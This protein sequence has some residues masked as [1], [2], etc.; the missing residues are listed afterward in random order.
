MPQ[1]RHLHPLPPRS[2]LLPLRAPSSCSAMAPPAPPAHSSCSAAGTSAPLV[3]LSHGGGGGSAPPA[4]PRRR[5]QLCP[6]HPARPQRRRQLRPP[7]SARPRQHRQ[8]RPPSLARA[9]APP[10]SAPAVAR[11]RSGSRPALRCRASAPARR[12]SAREGRRAKVESEM[13]EQPEPLGA[14]ILWL[15]TLPPAPVTGNPGALASE[16]E[17]ESGFSTVGQS[18]G[19]SRFWSRGRSPA[20]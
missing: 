5:R 14:S 12:R 16:L 13:E 4:R 3:R 2:S 15:L 19:W 18:S 7:R 11:H 10:S 20:K 17:P 9:A 8:L 1:R 6:P